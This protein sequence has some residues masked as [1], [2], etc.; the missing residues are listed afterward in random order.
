MRGNGGGPTPTMPPLESGY[1]PWEVE[2]P[3]WKGVTKEQWQNSAA[4]SDFYEK[5]SLPK[6]SDPALARSYGCRV[7][8]FAPGSK[9]WRCLHP[10]HTGT[11]DA[12]ATTACGEMLTDNDMSNVWNGVGMPINP[13]PKCARHSHA[14]AHTIC[15]ALQKQTRGH[16]R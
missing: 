10:M 6:G 11:K 13:P 1:E 7:R 14:R 15:T 5:P 12:P 16:V 8:G 9:S 3:V 2:R 4:K